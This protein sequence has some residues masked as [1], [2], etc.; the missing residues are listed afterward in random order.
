M[1]QEKV[2]ERPRAD[3]RCRSV[4]SNFPDGGHGAQIAHSPRRAAS[5]ERSAPGPRRPQAAL[6]GIGVGRAT[7]R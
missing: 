6:T 5:G 3:T 1:L 2:E 7:T 4:Q